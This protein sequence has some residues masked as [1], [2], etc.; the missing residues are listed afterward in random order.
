MRARELWFR[1]FAI[2]AFVAAASVNAQTLD[3]VVRVAETRAPLRN[4]LIVII[5]EGSDKVVDSTRVDTAGVFYLNAAERGT[6]RV[7]I[8]SPPDLNAPT[9][10]APSVALDSA[11]TTERVYLVPAAELVLYESQVEKPAR[12]KV[13]TPPKYPSQLERSRIQGDVI[14]QFVVTSAGNVDMATVKALSSPSMDLSEA[15]RLTLLQSVFYPA[16]INGHPVS[17]LVQQ[18]FQFRVPHH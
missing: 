17:Q 12:P 14:M 18:R 7:E 10:N 9:F 2:S 6:Y 1:I 13:E 16:Q 4:A 5:A 15:V 3:G 8:R 11:I